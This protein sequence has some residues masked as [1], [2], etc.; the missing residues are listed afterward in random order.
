LPQLL[1]A[2]VQ[3]LR[4]ELLQESATQARQR[5]EQYA[6]ALRGDISGR[7]LWQREQLDSR[8]GVT[9]GS[10]RSGKGVG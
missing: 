9:R 7:S 8:L 3:H 4:L 6:A 2:G 1:R 10:L 5:V